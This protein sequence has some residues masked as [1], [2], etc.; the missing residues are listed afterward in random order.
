MSM[1][2]AYIDTNMSKGQLP[3]A[4]IKENVY[5]YGCGAV[6]GAMCVVLR[7]GVL[8]LLLY[9]YVGSFTSF[10]KFR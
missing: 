6:C 9:I 5:H 1:Y 4:Q 3:W 2:Q 7:L 10:I 8:Q